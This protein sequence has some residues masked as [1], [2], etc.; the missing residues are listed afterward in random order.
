[1]PDLTLRQKTSDRYYPR[2]NKFSFEDSVELALR[3][4]GVTQG[5]GPSVTP[6]P[7]LV[8]PLLFLA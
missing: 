5:H 3:T 7:G 8:R 4:H 6:S 1:M 2:F